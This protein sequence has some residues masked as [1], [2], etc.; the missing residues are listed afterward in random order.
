M[1]G[2]SIGRIAER[3]Y[4]EEGASM[5]GTIGCLR[6]TCASESRNHGTNQ[7]IGSWAGQGGSEE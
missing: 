7:A 6:D 2:E 3:V 1:C 4:M 5:R